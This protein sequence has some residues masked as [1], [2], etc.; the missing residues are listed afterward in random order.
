[1]AITKEVSFISD[2]CTVH[3]PARWE[4]CN[5][6]R[7]TG[8]SSAYLGAFTREDM[9]EEGPEFMEDYMAGHYDRP[10]DDC[11]GLGRVLVLDRE[12]IERNPEQ[13]AVLVKLDDMAAQMDECRAIT[14]AEQ[15]GGA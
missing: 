9:E 11:E 12:A 8:K 5:H 13:R 7:G 2:E 10:C 4:I 15:R 1:M 3:L 6:C 14:A